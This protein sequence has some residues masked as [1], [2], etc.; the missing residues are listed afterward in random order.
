[1]IRPSRY[2]KGQTSPGIVFA[3]SK[4]ETETGGIFFAPVWM[5]MALRGGTVA[6]N[7][8]VALT[9]HLSTRLNDIS[10]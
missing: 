9:V 2:E 4:N 5:A 3:V 7:T 1:M 6:A 8:P 10:F